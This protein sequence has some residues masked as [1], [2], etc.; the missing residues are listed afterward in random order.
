MQLVLR[1]TLY[2]P[3]QEDFLLGAKLCRPGLSGGGYN[4]KAGL[5]RF[6]GRPPWGRT[7]VLFAEDLRRARRRNQILSKS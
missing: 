5:T 4:K 3:A 1:T 7:A 2:I 6:F